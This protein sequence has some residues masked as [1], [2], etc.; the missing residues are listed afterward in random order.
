MEFERD[1]LVSPT[2]EVPVIEGEAVTA[3]RTRAIPAP[4][5]IFKCPQ[6]VSMRRKSARWCTWD[7]TAADSAVAAHF[8]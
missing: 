6:S 1:V 2:T 8:I 3:I 7:T 4:A 5:A